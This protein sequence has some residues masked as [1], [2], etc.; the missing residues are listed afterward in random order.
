MWVLSAGHALVQLMRQLL[1]LLAQLH[2]RFLSIQQFGTGGTLAL[3]GVTLRGAVIAYMQ[4][5][6]MRV[7]Q[8]LTVLQD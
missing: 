1:Q 8:R 3:A 2:Q 4:Q 6:L 5:L 7:S